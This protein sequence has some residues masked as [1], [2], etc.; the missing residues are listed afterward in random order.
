M[1]VKRMLEGRCA[2]L[3]RGGGTPPVV[4]RTAPSNMR[5]KRTAKLKSLRLSPFLQLIRRPV[6]WTA[7]WAAFL[8]RISK[9]TKLYKLFFKYAIFAVGEMDLNFTFFYSKDNRGYY[10]MEMGSRKTSVFSV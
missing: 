1:Q 8:R 2:P 3:Q 5:I 9:Q 10:E 4:R 7:R 6:R